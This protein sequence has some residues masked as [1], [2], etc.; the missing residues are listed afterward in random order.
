MVASNKHFKLVIA[1]KHWQFP[2]IEL[3]SSVDDAL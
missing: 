2:L 1:F 3:D